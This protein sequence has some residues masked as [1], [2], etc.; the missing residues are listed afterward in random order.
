MSLSS[1]TLSHPQSVKNV[2]ERGNEWEK[3]SPV[4]TNAAYLN[5]LTT[6]LKRD[7]IREA[8]YVGVVIKFERATTPNPFFLRSHSQVLAYD[9][10]EPGDVESVVEDIERLN[11]DYYGMYEAQQK[12]WRFGLEEEAARIR[13]L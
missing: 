12:D 7:Y 13:A 11:F 10:S 1:L 2:Q 6:L 4:Y 9:W 3:N 8:K 5:N